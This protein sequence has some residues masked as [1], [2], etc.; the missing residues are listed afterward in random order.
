MI[1]R[2]G[3]KERGNDPLL[4]WERGSRTGMN[5]GALTHSEGFLV[6]SFLSITI[7]LVEERCH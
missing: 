1:E 6:G 4:V 7:L 5:S 2:G 3:E